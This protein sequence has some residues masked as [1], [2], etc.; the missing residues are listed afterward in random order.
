MHDGVEYPVENHIVYVPHTLVGHSSKYFP[1][2][3][4][5][6]PSRYLQQPTTTSKKKKA[7]KQN[8]SSLEEASKADK[9]AWRFFEHGPRN[10]VGQDL[11]M[12]ILKLALIVTVRRFDFETCYGPADEGE[13]TE[14]MEFGGQAYQRTDCF[15]PGPN[16]GLPMRI[17]RATPKAKDN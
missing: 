6:D 5:F 4:K 9:D 8:E 3:T 13:K 1:D 17:T 2:P 12:I 14:N 11:A 7:R 16:E 15:I 10:C